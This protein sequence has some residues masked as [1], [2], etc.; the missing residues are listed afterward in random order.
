MKKQNGSENRQPKAYSR[1]HPIRILALGSITG[2]SFLATALIGI[3]A[4]GIIINEVPGLKLI[5][6]IAG[7]AFAIGFIWGLIKDL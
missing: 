2:G 5:G 6:I 1:Y 3:G 4:Y 7:I